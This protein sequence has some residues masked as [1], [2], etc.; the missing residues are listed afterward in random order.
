MVSAANRN[1]IS[2]PEPPV[3]SLGVPDYYDEPEPPETV[4][5]DGLV[6]GRNPAEE[7]IWRERYMAPGEV[8]KRDIERQALDELDQLRAEALERDAVEVPRLSGEPTRP[9]RSWRAGLP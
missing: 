9:D 7:D 4:K 1:S 3:G 5:L 8:A 2:P 6:M